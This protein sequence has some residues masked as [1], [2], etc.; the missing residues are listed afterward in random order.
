MP[1]VVKVV[2]RVRVVKLVKPV[3]FVHHVPVLLDLH[4]A[5][6]VELY[7][8][9]PAGAPYPLVRQV[10]SGAATP[11]ALSHPVRYK[12]ILLCDYGR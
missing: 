2:R 4:A 10:R 3:S 12:T 5:L 6:M 1:D 8:P 7:S 11:L 9:Y